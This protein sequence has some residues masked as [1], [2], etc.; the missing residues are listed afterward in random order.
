MPEGGACLR[1]VQGGSHRFAPLIAIEL[2]G[3]GIRAF[4]LDPGYV[5]TERQQANAEALGLVGHY[6][7]A[8]PSAPAA[9][10]AWLADH[11]EEMENGQT[12][13][14][15]KLVLDRGLHPDWRQPPLRHLTAGQPTDELGRRDE[16][17][18]AV[19]SP[20]TNRPLSVSRVRELTTWQ[21]TIRASPSTSVRGVSVPPIRH[22]IRGRAGSSRR[23]SAGPRRACR[24]RWWA[25]SGAAGSPPPPRG[26]GDR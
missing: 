4:N 23:R 2:G 9:A 16:A 18:R 13:K 14:A 24:R 22:P 8:P 11:G 21:C 6:V 17:T 1:R 19:R 5:D 26:D 20:G 7:G 12:V 3:E 25:G 10:I 15:L